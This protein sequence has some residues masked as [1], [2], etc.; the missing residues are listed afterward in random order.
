MHSGTL[1]LTIDSRLDHVV[2]VGLSVRALC[3]AVPLAEADTDAV[4]LCVVEAVNNA[5]EHAYG[6]SPGHA[7]EI[8]LRLDGVEL[9]IAVRDRGR[10]MDWP[11]ACALADGSADD[12]AEGGRGLFIIRSLMDALSYR[13]AD[14]WNALRMVKRLEVARRPAYGCR[15]GFDGLEARRHASRATSF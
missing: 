11:A 4:E 6:G 15:D 2:L 3:A 12:L 1:T 5:I 10:R 13:D 9:C 8:E 7:V 14:G